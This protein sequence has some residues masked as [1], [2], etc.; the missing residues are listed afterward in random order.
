MVGGL[1]DGQSGPGD[2]HLLLR[3]RVREAESLEVQLQDP[4]LCSEVRDFSTRRL[5]HLREGIIPAL[6]RSL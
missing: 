3:A 1:G 2:T 5:R 4:S 6:E